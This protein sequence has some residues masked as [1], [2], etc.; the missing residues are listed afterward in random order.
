MPMFGKPLHA[1]IRFH[2]RRLVR[3]G[4]SVLVSVFAGAEVLRD[5]TLRG[6]A[7]KRT[8]DVRGIARAS[9]SRRGR[10]MLL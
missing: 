4:P 9:V 10:D 1:R 5:R 2:S 7:L 8:I 3:R 6:I